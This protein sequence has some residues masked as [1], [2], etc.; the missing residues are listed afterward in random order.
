MLAADCIVSLSRENMGSLSIMGTPY[1]AAMTEDWKN[2]IYHY[3]DRPLDLP[4]PVTLDEDTALHIAVYSKQAQPLQDLLKIMKE[5]YFLPYIDST[6]P[7]KE[8]LMRKNEFGNTALHEATICGNYEAVRLLVGRCPDLLTEK[9]K[10]GETPLFTAAGFAEAEIVEFLLMSKPEQCV[11]DKCS[12]LEIHRKRDDGLPILSAAIKGQHF[13]TALMSL[14]LD[15]SIHDLKDID[16]VDALQLIAQMP[17][18]FASLPVKRHPKVKSQVETWFK[19]RKEQRDLESGQ[20]RE[21]GDLESGQGRESG[22]L[23]SGQGRESGDLESGSELNQRGGVLKYLKVPKGCWLARFWNQKTKHVFA[24]KL[25]RILI[26]N[27][28]S[29]N[30]VSKTITDEEQGLGGKEN[31]KGENKS[32]EITSEGK[33]TKESQR[34]HTAENIQKGENKCTEITSKG[35][36]T[37]G[38]SETRKEHIPLFIATINGIEEIVWEIID[39]Y[40]Y[41]IEKLNEEGQSILD[42]AVMHRQKKIFSL[43]K[44][45][46]VP[47]ARLHRVIDNMGNTLLHHVADM[48]HYRGG[49][50]P[51]PALQ[52][53]EELQ[54][55]EQVQEVIP[56]HYA[57][58]QNKTRKTAGDLFK[59]NHKEQLENAQKWIKETTQSCSTVAALVATVVFAAAYTVPGGSDENGTPNFITSPYFL[60]FTVSDV[61][62][63]ASSLTSLVV[64][65]SLLTSPFD[66]KEFHIS[67]PRKLLVGFTFLF[68]AVIT[69]MLSFGATILILIQSERKLTT[70]LLSIAA[71]LPV[72]VFAIMQFRLYVSFMGST[73]NILKITGKALPRFKA[74]MGSLSIRE[75]V[76]R[77]AIG[78]EWENM[79]DYYKTRPE[80]L[81]S[82]V[83]LSLDTGFH[84]AV[85]SNKGKPLEDLLKIIEK[86]ESSSEI[87]S[88]KRKNKFGNTALHE[89][90][91][92]GNYEAVRLLVERC[93]DLLSIPNED[94]ETP[95]F[96]AAG[97][98]QAGIVKFLILS[99]QEQC[100]DDQCR[101]LPIH[102]QRSKDDQSILGAAIVGQHFE[103]A[104]LLL[105]V[106]E[107]LHSM[108]DSK[109]RTALQLLAEIPSAFESLPARRYHEIKLK[110]ES[111]EQAS[112]GT[113]RD[114]ESGLGSS[115]KKNPEGGKVN[116][117]KIESKATGILSCCRFLP[118]GYWPATLAGLWNMKT[119]HVFALRL[120]KILI[121]RDESWDSVSG[122]EEGQDEK[123]TPPSSQVKQGDH[124]R[125][126][127]EELGVGGE[128]NGKGQTSEISSKRKDSEEVQNPTPQTSVINTKEKNM[129]KGQIPLFIA[130][131]NGII[132]IVSE[133]IE[134]HPHAVEHLNEKGQ[135]ILNVA[136]MHRRENIF[137]LVKQRKIPMARLHR[138]LDMEGNTLLHH[139]A[140]MECYR[141]GTKPGPALKLQEEL[142]WFEQVRDVIPSHYVTLPNYE[143]KT[144]GDLFN[145]SHKEQLENARTW[146]KETTQS[147][148]TVSALVATVVFAAAYTVPGGSDENGKPNFIDSPYFLVFTV[149]DVLSLASSL[150]SLDLSSSK[151]YL[152]LLLP[153]LRGDNDHAILW[154]NNFDTHSVGEK[155]DNITPFHCC[156]PSSISI[157]NNAIPTVRLIYGLYSQH[158]QDD[159]ERSV[160]VS[161]PLPTMGD[162]EA[163]LSPV[164]REMDSKW[165]CLRSFIVNTEIRHARFTKCQQFIN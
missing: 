123:Q 16:G 135:S 150:T 5:S 128:T 100:V 114:P 94:G 141:G 126:N 19:E 82:P 58:L 153:L 41:S 22:D 77:S 71:F 107:S 25:A 117:K 118:Q 106:D 29:L 73:V 164:L 90:T 129:R 76:Y 50:K 60:V 102:R 10:Y 138:V 133:I 108:E 27:D 36:D 124:K 75:I 165:L 69:T 96:T 119:E 86:E 65:L 34:P 40:P 56:S 84:L 112:Q 46:K 130:T 105:E 157:C 104:L 163:Q 159:L 89:A 12:L 154:G 54:W 39:R 144:A 31:R 81:L 64:F 139:V 11:N 15:E 110:E 97:F 127:E 142:Q 23:E 152:G 53:Q 52:L 136:V 21:S 8:F 137:S 48:D 35:K 63:L 156:I 132:E 121:E 17:T 67:L 149:S 68:F 134:I 59:V 80:Q 115:S 145:A 51:G 103:T 88:L 24:L 155:V 113:V 4:L 49:T 91:I 83:T 33:H 147:C 57:T 109:K 28:K 20:G 72:L 62:S 151:T 116:R 85:H 125:K 87:E 92:N 143:G 146:I 47:L 101:M 45:Q 7:E 161:Y 2:M 160:I 148:S 140:D 98:G 6:A 1:R 14:Q 9:N 30:K 55:F 162:V 61:L 122:T 95:L 99:H 93:A 78:G 43:V 32:S 66:L 111:S 158:S 131:R 38:S 44:Q 70:L 37:A 3:Q 74:N 79:V 26:K 13:E 42:V 18:A 120:A